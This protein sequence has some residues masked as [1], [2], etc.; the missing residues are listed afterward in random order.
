MQP[1]TYELALANAERVRKRHAKEAKELALR[2]LQQRAAPAPIPFHSSTQYQG[3]G[4]MLGG[5]QPSEEAL[6]RESLGWAEIG[7]RAICD[8]MAGLR[9]VVHRRFGSGPDEEFEPLYDHPLQDILDRP[10]PDFSRANTLRLIA[11]HLVFVG[12]AY[13]LK[14]RAAGLRAPSGG[15]LIPRELW[16][17]LPPRVT[18]MLK[19]ARV[20]G[21]SVTDGDGGQHAIEPENV[22]RIWL[23]DIETLY[24]SRGLVG[25]QAI[26]IDADKFSDESTRSHFQFDA[27]PRVVVQGREDA[28]MPDKPQVKQWEEQWRTKYNRRFGDTRGLPAWL[29]TGF[30]LKELS[31]MGGMSELVPLKAHFR[32]KIM[33]AMGV[34]RSIVGD[35]V[36]ANRAAAE[37]N[38]WVFDVHTMTPLTAVV[39]DAFTYHLAR[40]FGEDLVVR[41][42][43][44]AAAD[45]EHELKRTDQDLRT[46]VRVVNEVRAERGMDEAPWGELPVGT[47]AEVPYT[48][49][50]LSFDL[51]P[52]EPD[53]E[54]SG[55]APSASQKG[56][57]E[58]E[59]ITGSAVLNGAQVQAITDLMAQVSAGAMPKANAAELMGVA[60]GI[61]KATAEKILPPE[62]TMEPIEDE[63]ARARL[64]AAGFFVPMEGRARFQANDALA[65]ASAATG[66]APHISAEWVRFVARE[67]ALVPGFQA[68]M[69]AIFGVQERA[70]MR[71]LRDAGLGRSAQLRDLSADEIRSVLIGLFGA[72][73]SFRDLFDRKAERFRR[74]AFERTAVEALETV[75]AQAGLEVVKFSY[76]P[77]MAATLA[78][79][80]R[81]F[82][83]AVNNTTLKRLS[84]TI[85]A[86]LA[87]GAAQGESADQ[88][89]KRVEKAVKSSMKMRRRQ[90]RMI[91]RTEML[92]AS[93]SAQ[94]AGYKLS[95]VVERKR[96][97]TSQDDA[98]RDS[99]EIDG[100]EVPLDSHFILPEGDGHAAENAE[101]PGVGIEG[102]RLSAANS[103][104]CRCFLTAVID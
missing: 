27:V 35:V 24:G 39:A 50:E 72:P 26:A 54:T 80:G 94:V 21:Y 7:A 25:P 65:R 3:M 11:G 43:E 60:F 42:P 79:Q 88:M 17:M 100:Q 6:L 48:G 29:P 95:G 19:G 47:M 69:Q 90:A 34:P 28:Q 30:E 76:T 15:P 68:I 101:A 82:R 53:G 44:F 8:R 78:A 1:S 99:H 59:A 96:W 52:E 22:V 87:E 9:P 49:E 2:Q 61:D 91:A 58:E 92:K 16:M 86:V 37:T 51:P 98:V 41:F 57:S 14:V 75:A 40:D 89:A 4:D 32:D 85:T 104:N 23:P 33:M 103:I 31:A 70:T 74:R 102:A 10:N 13:L 38:Q 73:D 45:K 62:G 71:A 5:H 97:N 66:I 77:T 83:Q 93:Q 36:D 56:F 64:M 55:P 12:E 46:K 84:G 81:S 67:R 18:P 63:D 20:V